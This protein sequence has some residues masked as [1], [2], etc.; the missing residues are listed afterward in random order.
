ML[1]VATEDLMTFT[2]GALA[3]RDGQ[4]DVVVYGDYQ[5]YD[6]E[7]SE[8]LIPGQLPVNIQDI[9]GMYDMLYKFNVSTLYKIQYFLQRCHYGSV[10]IVNM[11]AWT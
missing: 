4:I 10:L 9:T 11:R 7:L 2:A 8:I 1:Q 5:D 3:T 6:L